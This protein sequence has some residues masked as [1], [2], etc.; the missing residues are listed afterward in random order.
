MASNTY[1][2]AGLTLA[3]RS[4]IMATMNKCSGG[5][6]S[7]RTIGP[8]Q[9]ANDKRVYVGALIPMK[10]Y[11]LL[12]EEADQANVSRS[13]VLRRALVDRYG[14]G[15]TPAAVQPPVGDQEQDTKEQ[16]A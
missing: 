4:A 1:L 9:D 12:V 14:E 16:D 2:F 6:M 10:H 7:E 13:E 15:E 3:L 5:A 11:T 8:S